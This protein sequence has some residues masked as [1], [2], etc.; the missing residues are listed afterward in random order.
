MSSVTAPAAGPRRADLA[1]RCDGTGGE[2]SGFTRLRIGA[3]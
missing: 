2:E 3:V 1:A